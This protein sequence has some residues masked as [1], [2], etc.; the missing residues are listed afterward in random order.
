MPGGKG[1]SFSFSASIVYSEW[2][3]DRRQAYDLDSAVPRTRAER[4]F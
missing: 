4:V 3:L 1:V 2:G